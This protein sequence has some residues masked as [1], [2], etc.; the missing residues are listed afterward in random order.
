LLI[1]F[2][3]TM[4]N[5]YTISVLFCFVVFTNCSKDFLK[6]Y[7]KR[8]I[9][10]WRI[11]DVRDYGLGGNTDNLPFTEGSFSFYENGVLSYVN[12]G[13][14][15]FRGTWDIVKKI[16]EDQTVH[17]L[18]ITAVNYATMQTL[19]EYYDDMNFTG[20]DRFKASITSGFH[21]YVTIFKR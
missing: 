17:S 8:I 10:T 18:E 21:T 1:Q 3:Y 11:S 15:T 16:R 9:G 6:K 5:I 13:N 14:I 4:K 7:D 20:T 2:S 19:S 12:S